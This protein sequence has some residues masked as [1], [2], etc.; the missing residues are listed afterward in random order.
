VIASA[1]TSSALGGERDFAWIAAAPMLDQPTLFAVAAA[2]AGAATTVHVVAGP[3]GAEVVL[4]PV[5]GGEA[6]ALSL[7]PGDAGSIDLTAGSWRIEAT[8][9]VHAAV[10]Y[11]SPTAVAGYPVQPGQGAAAAV[12]VVP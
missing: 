4:T 1:W 12:R 6:R 11:A 2:P 10:S 8:A 9:P 5:N 7:T 3:E